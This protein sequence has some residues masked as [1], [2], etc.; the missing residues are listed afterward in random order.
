MALVREAAGERDLGQRLRALR[1]ERGGLLDA[2]TA[3]VLARRAAE[4]PAKGP[5]Q[6]DGVDTHFKPAVPKKA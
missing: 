6:V 2:A 3:E 4:M 1:Q 5:R